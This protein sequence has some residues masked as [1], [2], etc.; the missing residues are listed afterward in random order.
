MGLNLGEENDGKNQFFERPVLVIKKFNRRVAWVVP[1]STKVKYNRYYH[2]HNYNGK[3]FSILLSQ[4]K[5]VSVKRLRRFSRKMGRSE[6]NL[7][8]KKLKQIL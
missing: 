8:L 5:L 3:I 2:L 1:M 4:L 7:I 6:F